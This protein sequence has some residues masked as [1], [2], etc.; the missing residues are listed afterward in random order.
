MDGFVLK[1]TFYVSD[2]DGRDYMKVQLRRILEDEAI[3]KEEIVIQ[4]W[5]PKRDIV[6]PFRPAEAC[7][8]RDDL[9]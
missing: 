4:V 7:L 1:N 3:S 2:E 8:G 9:K 5:I 6:L